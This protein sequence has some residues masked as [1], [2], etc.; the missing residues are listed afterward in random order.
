[1][2]RLTEV[3][4]GPLSLSNTIPH[5]SFPAAR[6]K[7][8]IHSKKKIFI[9]K[10]QSKTIS[11][12]KIFFILGTTLFLFSCTQ[13]KEN[14]EAAELNQLA[15]KYVRLGLTIGQY[16]GDF[17]D[18]YYGPDSLKPVAQ[19]AA[20]FPKDSLLK[21]AAEMKTAFNTIASS[22]TNDTLRT[23][24]NWISSQLTAFERRIKIFSGQ[25][26]RF[27]EE[28]AELFGTKAP[29]NTEDYFKTL[30]AKLDLHQN[31]PYQKV[32]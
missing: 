6:Q 7:R 24:A 23:R 28:A 21:A 11:M 3:T 27:D 13:K 30:V 1:L 2:V 17:V 25:L 31:L 8:S 10:L 12:N 20:V 18:A 29:A 9:F 15:E 32:R 19:K 22:T 4:A 26:S 5:S 16:D 14:N